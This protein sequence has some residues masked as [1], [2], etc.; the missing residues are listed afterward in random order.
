MSQKV[1]TKVTV[2]DYSIGIFA[3]VKA[4]HILFPLPTDTWNQGCS[5]HC[6]RGYEVPLPLGTD[7]LCR[8]FLK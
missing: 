1:Q 7:Y 3:L 2:L 8:L 6:M 4:L 5:G